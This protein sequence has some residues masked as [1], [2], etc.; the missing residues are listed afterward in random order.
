ML[1]ARHSPLYPKN[2]RTDGVYPSVDAAYINRMNTMAMELEFVFRL[3][4]ECAGNIYY[5]ENRFGFGAYSGLHAFLKVPGGT[6][7]T[8]VMELSLVR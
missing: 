8:E 3:Q 4:T 7:L 1:I 5:M 6:V 2:K